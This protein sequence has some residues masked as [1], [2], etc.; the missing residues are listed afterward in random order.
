MKK[1]LKELGSLPQ[2]ITRYNIKK[3]ADFL[4]KSFCEMLDIMLTI[5]DRKQKKINF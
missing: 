4:I 5:T 2:K 1:E 3:M